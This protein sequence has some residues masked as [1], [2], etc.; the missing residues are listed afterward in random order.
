MYIYSYSRCFFIDA[1]IYSF[2]YSFI[3]AR[4]R[5][6]LQHHKFI[7]SYSC[8]PEYLITVKPAPPLEVWFIKLDKRH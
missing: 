3:H 8:S 4:I 2:T 1:F 5:G 6:V 7:I